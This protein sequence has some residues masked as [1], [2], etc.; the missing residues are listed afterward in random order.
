M[1]YKV[2][3][4]IFEGPFDL[5]VYLIENAEMN[6]YDIQVAEI[7][8]QYLRHI[9]EMKSKDLVVG[10]EFMVL[11]AALIE[12]KSK[13]L[14]P[15]Y[16]PDGTQEEEDPRNEL[17]QKLL[18]YKRFK[19]AAGFLAEREEF[20]SMVLEKPKEDLEEFTCEPDEY[21]RMDIDMFVRAFEQFLNKKQRIAEVRRRYSRAE[22]ERETMESRIGHIRSI[23]R[24]NHKTNLKF[25]ELLKPESDRYEIVLTFVSLLEMIKGRVLKVKQDANFGEISLELCESEDATN[26]Q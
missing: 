5:L 24:R 25:W 18:E 10:G 12:L 7:T 8:N 21:L 16:K 3:I 26:V 15:R 13:M 4:D 19:A 17:V 11:A 6:I 23:F 1:S 22:R 9:E 2:K 20:A 14:L